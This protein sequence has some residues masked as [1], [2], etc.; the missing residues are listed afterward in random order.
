MMARRLVTLYADESPGLTN[1]D[2]RIAAGVAWEAI[3]KSATELGSHLIVLGP[4]S[5]PSITTCLPKAKGLLGSTAD[6]VIR[7]ANCPV[8]IINRTFA[9]RR[10]Q[11][12][13]IVIGIDFSRACISAL[14]LAALLATYFNSRLHPFHML[15][16]PPYPKYTPESYKV[17]RRRIKGQLTTLCRQLLDGSA[18]QIR[19]MSGTIPHTALLQHARDTAADLIVIGSHT[20]EKAGK[21]YP[22]SV[23]Q[24]LSFQAHCPLLVVNGPDALIHWKDDPRVTALAFLEIPPLTLFPA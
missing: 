13:N 10:L 7:H 14:C 23:A 21:W 20:K 2:V 12:K 17:D 24:Q 22:G 6:G 1:A 8:M 3:F 5:E 19:I 9:T 4:H 15:P 16:I 18:Y 11:F